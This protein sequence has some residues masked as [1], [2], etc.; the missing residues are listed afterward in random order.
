MAHVRFHR[1]V[2]QHELFLNN[3]ARASAGEQL[4][5]FGFARGKAMLLRHGGACGFKR[6]V[7][8]LLLELFRKLGLFGRQGRC[9]AFAGVSR[10]AF[11]M[12]WPNAFDG[13]GEAVIAHAHIVVGDKRERDRHGNPY[14]DER[15]ACRHSVDELRDRGANTNAQPLRSQN[16]CGNGN[17][18]QL[19]SRA[20]GG[21]EAIHEHVEHIGSRAQKRAVRLHAEWVAPAEQQQRRR[22]ESREYEQR[23]SSI[24]PVGGNRPARYNDHERNGDGDERNERACS[25]ELIFR[26]AQ[27]EAACDVE[28]K[29]RDE[30]KARERYVRRRARNVEH[31]RSHG[32]LNAV[33][34]RARVASNEC[35]ARDKHGDEGDSCQAHRRGQAQ[36]HE[37]AAKCVV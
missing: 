6:R 17:R 24:Q 2:R 36:R 29:N 34:N 15:V 3:G 31:G 12:G 30:R 11:R 32:I 37:P 13:F 28:Q 16:R 20:N 35:I 22:E 7:I 5:Y 33:E 18:A 10:E 23:G 1:V 14:G 26:A 27:S 8:G 21:D 4:E 9:A 19:V 25:G